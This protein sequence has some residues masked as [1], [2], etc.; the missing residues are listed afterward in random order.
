MATIDQTHSK[1]TTATHPAQPG[2]NAMERLEKNVHKSDKCDESLDRRGTQPDL[3]IVGRT[4]DANKINEN[5]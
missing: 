2:S 4:R 1:A 5:K 3:K